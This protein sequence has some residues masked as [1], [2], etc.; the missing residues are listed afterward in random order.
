MGGHG[1]LNITMQK[2]YAPYTRKNR[3]RVERDERAQ[4]EAVAAAARA[5]A[6]A[7]SE[8]RLEALRASSGVAVAPV[9]HINF[10]ADVELA[11][12]NE[13]LASEARKREQSLMSRLLPD[14]QLGRSAAEPKPWYLAPPKRAAPSTAAPATGKL[15]APPRILPAEAEEGAVKRS[16]RKRRDSPKRH[17]RGRRS[18]RSS[19]PSSSS[20]SSSDADA[21][22][23]HRNAKSERTH[24]RDSDAAAAASAS[25]AA[26]LDVLRKERLTRELVERERARLVL[27]RRA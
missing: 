26:A 27:A 16:K 5:E 24:R 14:L 9:E 20:T 2:S 11:L 4:A 12:H 19:P 13:Q 7:A 22:S 25:T 18:H 8:L 3:E 23:H 21:T 6:A 1:G 10:F 17:K 15:E